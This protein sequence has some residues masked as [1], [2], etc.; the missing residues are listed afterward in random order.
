MMLPVSMLGLIVPAAA[1]LT[2]SGPP[3]HDD[4]MCTSKPLRTITAWCL[5]C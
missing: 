2:A 4:V 1:L 3:L 5:C